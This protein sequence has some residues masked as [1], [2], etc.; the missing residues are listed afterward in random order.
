[1]SLAEKIK[2]IENLMDL[3]CPEDIDRRKLD[4]E[5]EFMSIAEIKDDFWEFTQFY[6]DI[7]DILNDQYRDRSGINRRRQR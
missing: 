7:R 1:M 2:A 4:A 6:L 3:F 5:I